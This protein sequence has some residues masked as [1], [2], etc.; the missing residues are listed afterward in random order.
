MAADLPRAGPRL[1][2]PRQVVLVDK[3]AFCGGNST[4]AGRPWD[5]KGAVA[6]EGGCRELGHQRDQWR[7]DHDPEGHSSPM[8][9]HAGGDRNGVQAKKV[10]DT[11]DLFTSDT[12][13]G[14]AKKP[15][16]VKAC[17][18]GFWVHSMVD[19]LTLKV[20][21][22]NS[23]PDVDWLVDKFD[24]DMR[25]PQQRMRRRAVTPTC[26]EVTARTSWRPLRTPNPPR[27]GALPRP[28]LRKCDLC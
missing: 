1:N 8:Q 11:V 2:T 9:C 28:Q 14:G 10:E 19:F 4:K 12:L 20:L 3:S 26:P 5:C 25:E 27:Q 18:E 16:L 24:L 22:G 6:V 15:E 17:K 13:K 21:C 7:R 23:G